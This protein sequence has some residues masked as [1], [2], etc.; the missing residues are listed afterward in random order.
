MRKSNV[1]VF[2]G[3]NSN[4]AMKRS[5]FAQVGAPLMPAPTPRPRVCRVILLSVIFTLA[6]VIPS[7]AASRAQTEKCNSEKNVCYSGCRNDWPPNTSDPTCRRDCRW[8]WSICMIEL[9]ESPNG[10][11]GP[12]PKK[13]FR[14]KEATNPGLS[15]P[16]SGG[17][18]VPPANIL[19]TSPGLSPQGPS[20]MGTPGGAP[21]GPKGPVFQ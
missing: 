11:A 17:K 5:R 21:A 14:P 4:S 9:G 12:G 6:W 10:P 13:N 2:V 20:G 19:E 16:T 1:R 3:A 8:D 18:G 7:V 15:R